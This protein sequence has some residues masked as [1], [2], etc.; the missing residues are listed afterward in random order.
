MP[1]T[2]RRVEPRDV[3]QCITLE[4]RC[5]PP[6]E[7]ASPERVRLRAER[8]PEGFLVG[9]DELGA[10]VG[11]VMSGATAKEDISDEGLKELVGHDPRGAHAVVFSVAVL[12]ALQGQ[13][14]GR[15][16]LGRFAD[17]ARAAGRES[18]LLLCKAPLVPFYRRLGYRDLGPSAS[19]HGGATWHQMK[20]A[21]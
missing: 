3:P 10:I 16:L 21:L 11:L 17:E 13:G 5:F 18:I 6:E 8:F 9:E 20:L 1:P 4:Q 15:L 12:P 14:L 2:L 19:T 7:A